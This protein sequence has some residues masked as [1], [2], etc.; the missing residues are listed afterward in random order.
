VNHHD[1]VAMATHLLYETPSGYALFDV[2]LHED[3]GSKTKAG[4]ESITDFAK[5]SKMVSLKSFSPFKSAAEALE[6]INDISE[7]A[8]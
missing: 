4:Q 3:I 5:F 1:R 7:G 2:K 8:C 6:N